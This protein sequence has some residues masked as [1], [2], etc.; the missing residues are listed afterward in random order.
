[1]STLSCLGKRHGHLCAQTKMTWMFWN[2]QP[3]HPDRNRWCWW[4]GNWANEHVELYH[5][6]S[7]FGIP[8][9]PTVD[10]NSTPWFPIKWPKQGGNPWKS[11]LR[12][13]APFKPRPLGMA[14]EGLPRRNWASPQDLHPRPS[15]DISL[16]QFGIKHGVPLWTHN[17]FKHIPVVPTRRSEVSE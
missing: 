4:N 13:L 7:K 16:L 3:L 11:I 2:D 14:A 6:L 12:R 10:H 15:L 17:L 5:A 9:H 1:M 8:F